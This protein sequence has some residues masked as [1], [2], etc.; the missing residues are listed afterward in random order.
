M[1]ETI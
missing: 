1:R